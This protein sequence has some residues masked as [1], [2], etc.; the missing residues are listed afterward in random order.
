ML[1]R[2]LTAY[3]HRFDP[4]EL[5]AYLLLHRHSNLPECL[6]QLPSPPEPTLDSL[7]LTWFSSR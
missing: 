5:L 1:G 2:L 7:A 6:A 4:R 3:G